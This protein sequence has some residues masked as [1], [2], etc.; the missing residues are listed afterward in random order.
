MAD[1]EAVAKAILISKLLDIDD[2]FDSVLSKK[3]WSR[4]IL[5]IIYKGITGKSSGIIMKFWDS[6]KV[7][8]GLSE[9]T[10]DLEKI[11]QKLPVS[12]PAAD[13][14]TEAMRSVETYEEASPSHR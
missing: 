12:L 4:D 1:S 11:L 2:L 3:K 13:A 9:M 14:I 8:Y 6:T 5:D 7:P 10:S